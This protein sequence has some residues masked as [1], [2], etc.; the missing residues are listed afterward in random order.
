MATTTLSAAIAA[1]TIPPSMFSV[2]ATATKLIAPPICR[3][4]RAH[5]TFHPCSKPSAFNGI[6]AKAAIVPITVLTAPTKKA[7][8][9]DPA[10]LITRFKSESNRKSGTASGTRNLLISPYTGEENGIRPIF[11]K[12]NVINMV[13]RGAE[14]AFPNVVFCSIAIPPADT[15]SKVDKMKLVS[16]C[17]VPRI[18]VGDISRAVDDSLPILAR[19]VLT[20]DSLLF[21]NE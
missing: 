20:F 14:R 16:L 12:I 2:S 13:T 4:A 9:R 19:W 8:S 6:N 5:A 21:V 7:R 15:T 17:S 3:A 1:L 10:S 11:A 18:E